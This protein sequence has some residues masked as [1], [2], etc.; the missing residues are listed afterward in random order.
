MES[1]RIASQPMVLG[2][3]L[4]M[5]ALLTFP[6]AVFARQ[7]QNSTAKQR[8]VPSQFASQCG[9]AVKWRGDLAEAFRESQSTGKPIFWYVPTIGGSFMDRKKVINRYLLAGPFSWPG[10]SELLNENFIPVQ[11]SAAGEMQRRYSLQPY[12]FVEPGFLVLN[13]DGAEVRKVD[14]LTTLNPNWMAHLIASSIGSDTPSLTAS[15]SLTEAWQALADGDYEFDIESAEVDRQDRVE[16]ILLTGMFQFRQGEH[17]KA[18]D[19][20]RTAG[21]LQPEHPL[22][23]KCMAE[24]ENWGP[25]VR[26]FE[27][28]REIPDRSIQAGVDSRGSA[29]P[30]GTFTA[31]QI[32]R[33]SADYLLAMQRKD[34]S[35]RDSDYDFGGFDSFPNVYVAVTALCGTALVDSLAYVDDKQPVIDAVIQ[36]AAYCADV[37]NLNY[38]DRDEILWA[39][40][41]RVRLFAK[42]VSMN[43]KLETS[44]LPYLQQAVGDLESIQTARGSWYH[45]YQNPFVTATALTA[46]KQAA[47]A[48]ATVDQ[49]RIKI[50]VASLANERYD[51]GAYPY[52]GV[53]Q[54]RRRGT[55]ASSGD[56]KIPES[57][58]R[59]PLC[60]TA[61]L[62]WGASDNQKLNHA[63]KASLEHHRHLASGYKYDNH[64][65]NMGYGG[66]F[67]W[68]DMRS[69]AEALAS[70]TAGADR[71]RFVNEHR[72]LVMALPELDGCFVDSHELG[73]CY[74]TAMAL[75]TMATLD[76]IDE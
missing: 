64:T 70:L 58:G 35:W 26:G 13:S 54:V 72:A 9:T 48:G 41:Y 52:Y 49:E 63:L 59:M 50:G 57:A 71:E 51:N 44:Y 23:W 42:L 69:R 60:E 31:E 45:E 6:N 40:A 12:K 38:S 61:L 22:A 53:K 67:F 5:V 68:Y 73:R 8:I 56:G 11:A 29:A 37:K 21:Q 27:V 4:A 33:R 46:L 17:V 3:T 30:A 39:Q 16:K 34:G 7:Q 47:A 19:T 14:Q 32:W 66:F 15:E 20:W 24:S 62:Y 76:S 25:F 28:F 18:R 55:R 2:V 10:I 74:G 1:K 75:Q 43:D 65:S 36:A